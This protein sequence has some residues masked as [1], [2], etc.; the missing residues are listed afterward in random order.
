MQKEKEILHTYYAQGWSLKKETPAHYILKKRG[1]TAAG[2]I[3]IFLLGGF[4]LLGLANWIYYQSAK[5]V[6]LV[7]KE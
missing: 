5:K 6:K 1:D 7:E 3:L 4:L 2:H